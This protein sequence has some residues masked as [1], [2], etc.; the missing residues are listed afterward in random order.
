MGQ[1]KTVILAF[2]I[3][4]TCLPFYVIP[5]KIHISHL[6]QKWYYWYTARLA[7]LIELVV[8]VCSPSCIYVLLHHLT[9]FPEAEVMGWLISMNLTYFHS[10]LA[11]QTINYAASHKEIG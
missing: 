11:T 10:S 7:E 1:N 5:Q 4:K 8:F 3:N 9:C 6:F 2:Q